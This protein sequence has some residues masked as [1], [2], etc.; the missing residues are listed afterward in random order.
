MG[1]QHRN[2]GLTSSGLHINVERLPVRCEESSS[3]DSS[4]ISSRSGG[5][6]N[7]GDRFSSALNSLRLFFASR[8]FGASGSSRSSR[9]SSGYGSLDSS[10][11]LDESY[12][13]VA[14]FSGKLINLLEHTYM[15]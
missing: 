13:K 10:W 9:L 12:V 2:G 4:T 8:S 1:C 11:E 5:V 3:L 14:K 6:E 7:I 15:F